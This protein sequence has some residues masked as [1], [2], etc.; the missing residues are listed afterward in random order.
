MSP[1]VLVPY[2]FLATGAL[3]LACSFPGC[4]APT[5]VKP[6]EPQAE[7]RIA[8]SGPGVRF[9]EDDTVD[10][11][12]FSLRD[13]DVP[14]SPAEAIPAPEAGILDAAR[15]RALLARLPDLER[16]GGDTV[17][18]ALRPGSA[19]P[20]RT[21]KT[22]DV[23]FP[24]AEVVAQ[25]EPGT[26]GELEVLRFAPEGEVELAPRLNVTFSRPMVAVTSQEEAAR[27]VPARLAP[28]PP[29]SW[30]WL[31]TRT[32]VFQPDGRFPMATDYEV[33]IPAETRST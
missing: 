15:T 21:G 20:P 19:P 26:P 24:P 10:G 7:G 5:T 17:A 1:R 3:F 14:F 18:F 4:G 25:P 12:R 32:L 33:Q 22:V 11:L 27:T 30:R 29:G 8:G 31:G 6:A 16:K 28:E 9:V 13:A 2:L 23:P